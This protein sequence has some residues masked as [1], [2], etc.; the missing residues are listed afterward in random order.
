[1]MGTNQVKIQND[2]RRLANAAL[3]KFKI[4]LLGTGRTLFPIPHSALIT[5]YSLLSTQLSTQ[6]FLKVN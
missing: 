2:A 3:T 4:K 6:H 1:M 5:H